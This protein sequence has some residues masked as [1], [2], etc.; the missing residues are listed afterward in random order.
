[1]EG[2]YFDRALLVTCIDG[3]GRLTRENDRPVYR[4]DIDTLG[5]DWSTLLQT[6]GLCTIPRL[7]S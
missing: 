6:W 5:A 3:L 7:A 2:T 4:K 1:M